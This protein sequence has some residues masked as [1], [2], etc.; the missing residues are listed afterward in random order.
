MTERYPLPEWMLNREIRF[1][2]S[3][4]HAKGYLKNLPSQ[5]RELVTRCAEAFVKASK[6]QP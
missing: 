1:T 3:K 5:L 6:E 4:V 2:I